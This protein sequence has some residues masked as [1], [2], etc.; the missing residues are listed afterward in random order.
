MREKL[1]S[2][3]CQRKN[4]AKRLFDS[5]LAKNQ[6]F[7]NEADG[8]RLDN[9]DHQSAEHYPEFPLYDVLSI[10]KHNHG[11]LNVSSLFQCHGS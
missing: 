1:V 2:S 6:I 9:K 11:F 3:L 8:R 5:V 7:L 4:V 10:F